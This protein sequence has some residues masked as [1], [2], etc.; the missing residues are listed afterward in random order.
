[1]PMSMTRTHP[2]SHMKVAHA[3]A[4]LSFSDCKAS[5]VGQILTRSFS[6]ECWTNVVTCGR[7]LY[8]PESAEVCIAVVGMPAL[9]LYPGLGVGM[10][11]GPVF[12]REGHMPESRIG[13]QEL[14]THLHLLARK[15]VNVH[16]HAFERAFRLDI[17]QSE[18]L[19]PGA[20]RRNGNQRAMSADRQ[21]VSHFFRERCGA[22][23]NREAHGDF[24][25]DPLT[26][27]A[28]GREPGGFAGL[29]SP[30]IRIPRCSGSTAVNMRPMPLPG[31]L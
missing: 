19:S 18:P 26:P 30:G 13:Q 15:P 16:D 27:A 28:V 10:A 22:G 6:G 11:W 2:A 9:R 4:N 12:R 1:M 23:L 25:Q 20:R 31:W 5:P 14:H 3:N 29:G 17:R 24:H 21:G 7:L 8:H